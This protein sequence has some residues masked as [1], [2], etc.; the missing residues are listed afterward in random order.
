MSDLMREEF[1][2]WVQGRSL[3]K[4]RGAKLK[5]DSAGSYTDY[6]VNDLWMAWQASREC[7]VIELPR[8][9]CADPEA[10]DYAQSVVEHIESLGIKVKP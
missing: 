8:C 9:Y 5:K 2:C 7:L 3:C 10:V 4:K 1:E 6:R